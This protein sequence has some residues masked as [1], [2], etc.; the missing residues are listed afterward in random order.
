MKKLFGFVFFVVLLVAAVYLSAHILLGRALE[1]FLGVPAKVGRVYVNPLKSEI[2]AYEIEILNPP[3]FVEKRM[4]FIPEIF[5]RY[6]LSK[7]RERRMILSLMRLVVMCLL[8]SSKTIGPVTDIS[9]SSTPVL[10]SSCLW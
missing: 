8:T 9:F 10:I 7:L 2:G 3:G 4:A 6:D 1:H 5:A